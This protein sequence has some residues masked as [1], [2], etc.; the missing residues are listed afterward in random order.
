MPLLIF[1]LIIVQSLITSAHVLF[2]NMVKEAFAIAPTHVST[3]G[4]WLLICLSVSFL[5]SSFLTTRYQ[6]RIGRLYYRI[7]AVW[8][9]L[10]YFLFAATCVIA[11]ASFILP[12]LHIAFSLNIAAEICYGTALALALYGVWNVRTPAIRNVTVEIPH[13]PEAWEHKKVVFFSDS[14]F[15]N[16][17][18]ERSARKLAEM[19]KSLEP[20]IVLIGGDFFDG[21]AIDFYTVAAPFRDIKTT[22]GIYFVTGNHESYQ[23]HQPYL[24]AL[25]DAGV[26]ILMN[27]WKEIDG[28]I[29]SGI[30][31][32]SSEN[33]EKQ[34]TLMAHMHIPQHK[35][36]ILLKHVPVDLHIAYDAHVDLQLSGHTHQGQLWPLSLLTKRIYKGYDVGLHPFP[37]IAGKDE[38]VMNVYTSTGAFGWGPPAR[39]GTKNEIVLLHL[40]N[41]K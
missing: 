31:Y 30:D 1:I 8:F 2:F 32:I 25:E 36:L 7:S 27:Q 14:H 37:R 5:I 23:P 4:F 3:V 16:I 26:H 24:H 21:P 17:F 35:P 22:H 15:G 10:F 18:N 9:A 6:S 29:I 12:L 40:T 19:I 20:D 39:V 28:L 41:K 11:L 38:R 33:T 13:L 34:K